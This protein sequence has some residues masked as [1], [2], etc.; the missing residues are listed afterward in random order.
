MRKK[1]ITSDLALE[2]Q[3]PLGVPTA[4][5]LTKLPQRIVDSLQHVRF[6]GA[7]DVA[8]LEK[9]TREVYV[10]GELIQRTGLTK[11]GQSFQLTLKKD[12]KRANDTNMALRTSNMPVSKV[13]TRQTPFDVSASFDA[14]AAAGVQFVARIHRSKIGMNTL[15]LA[16]SCMGFNLRAGERLQ[17]AYD[18]DA[19]VREKGATPSKPLEI[20]IHHVHVLAPWLAHEWFGGT[21]KGLYTRGRNIAV[22]V[23]AKNYVGLWKKP[24]LY[25]H[26]WYCMNH[27]P[28]IGI[29]HAGAC[30][31]A[32]GQVMVLTGPSALGKTE[33][34]APLSGLHT[35]GKLEFVNAQGV[36]SAVDVGEDSFAALRR[37]I[38][39]DMVGFYIDPTTGDIY[40][41]DLETGHWIRFDLYQKRGDHPIIDMLSA[42]GCTI[43][44]S[45]TNVGYDETTDTILPTQHLTLDGES[46]DNPR[47]AV[48]TTHLPDA[49]YQQTSLQNSVKADI[50][51]VGIPSA[52]NVGLPT[53]SINNQEQFSAVSIAGLRANLGNQ[54]IAAEGTAAWTD[55]G[56]FTLPPFGD[57]TEGEITS[58]LLSLFQR[59]NPSV[60]TA[61]VSNRASLQFTQ[62][63]KYE[64]TW[65]LRFLI[66]SGVDF[67]ALRL[68]RHV[69]E[70]AGWCPLLPSGFEQYQCL[71]DPEHT[72]SPAAIQS[73]AMEF[74]QKV[75]SR[76]AI[77]DL[78]Y[79][80]RQRQRELMRKWRAGK[81]GKAPLSL[82]ESY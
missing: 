65:L 12:E 73:A 77:V 41:F 81:I 21:Q 64:G 47:V 9:E 72:M 13:M 58:W 56:A 57:I 20:Q 82:V 1:L 42:P 25:A 26:E 67:R 78:N 79:T 28:E 32:N 33:I 75:L 49:F 45:W 18:I 60:L 37:L 22:T 5:R 30:K 16:P 3:R 2:I 71:L 35:P 14:Q 38:V 69:S 51:V 40:I 54:S 44:C 68:K 50:L 55:E 10:G 62:R 7:E 27:R 36:V 34:S 53:F 74:D 76:L 66:E 15:V 23:N 70:F 39:D 29:I 17:Q 61:L 43:P 63:N 19:A 11:G 46:T 80:L 4:V 52:P 48:E 24:F 6:V 31:L 59:L 8:A